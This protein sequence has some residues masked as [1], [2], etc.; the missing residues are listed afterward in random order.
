MSND[1]FYFE[2]VS[3]CNV[4]PKPSEFK[5]WVNATLGWVQLPEK[6][7][8][9]RVVDSAEMQSVNHQYRQQNNPTNVLSFPF[10]AV[11]EEQSELAWGDVLICDS[12]VLEQAKQ[13]GKSA[14]SHWAHMTVHG[15]LHLLGFDH[16]EDS[17]AAVMEDH[18]V[19][20][21]QSLGFSNPYLDDQLDA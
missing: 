16:I 9:I 12:V 7:L 10:D 20:I 8:S 2:N 15:T 18:E 21:M 6:E 5:G 1:W 13:Q 4:V 19:Q 14:L 11:I 3:A 17:D